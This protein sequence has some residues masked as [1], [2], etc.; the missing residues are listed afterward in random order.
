MPR[1]SDRQHLLVVA[2]RRVYRDAVQWRDSGDAARLAWALVV[3]SVSALRAE[4]RFELRA[5]PR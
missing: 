1:S 4:D 3:A 5:L 2:G